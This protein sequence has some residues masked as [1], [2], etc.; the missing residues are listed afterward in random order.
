M[1][2]G[3]EVTVAA[4]S[5]YTPRHPVVLVG[6]R[7]AILP[8][9]GSRVVREVGALSDAG[10]GLSLLEPTGPEPVEVASI[11][12]AAMACLS[13]EAAGMVTGPIH[14]MRLVEQGFAFR[15]H[16]DFLGSLCGNASPV[17]AFVGGSL[18]VALVTTHIPLG[19]VAGAITTARVLDVV[20][21]S[22]AA[23]VNDLGFS[24]PTLAVCGLNPH[25]GEEGLLGREELDTIGP[26][27]DQARARGL[28]VIGPVS[29]ET[30]FL[31]ARQGRIDL[32]VAMYHDQGL[33]PLKVVDFGRSV[34]WTV[35]LP[36]LRT[37]VD[38]GTA[39]SL[40][41]TGQADSAS[42]VA[43]LKLADQIATH[44]SSRNQDENP[45]E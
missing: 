36:I 43:A 44:R 16:T 24:A 12:F 33:A 19:A 30:A 34:N 22:H 38:H 35:G 20:C 23:L 8:L 27:C 26:A 3:P 21:T 18:R 5:E 28:N 40:V 11:R 2:I 25:A 31:Q 39:D 32:V 42:M 6:R 9:F 13:N 37:S 10:T 45:A 17:M 29:A 15:G 7:A 1:G 41:G 4:L 14:K